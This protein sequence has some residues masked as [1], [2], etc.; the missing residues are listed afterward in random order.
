MLGAD[1]RATEGSIVADKNCSKI[2]HISSKIWFVLSYQHYTHTTTS[3]CMRR[4]QPPQAPASSGG[5]AM[6]R[7]RTQQAVPNTTALLLTKLS[8]CCGCV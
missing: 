1:T 8:V 2:H 6:H 3:S 5:L 7:R 4:A